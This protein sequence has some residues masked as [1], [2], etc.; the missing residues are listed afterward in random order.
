MSTTVNQNAYFSLSK[1]STQLLL[2]TFCLVT[3]GIEATFRMDGWRRD[4]WMT[5]R[6][7][8]EEGQTDVDVE[9]VT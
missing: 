5:D 4:K 2:V 3:A 9:I 7:R 6:Q 1:Y 8:T